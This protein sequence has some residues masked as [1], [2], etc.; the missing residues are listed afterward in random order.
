ME[1]SIVSN[2]LRLKNSFVSYQF[3]LCYEHI[4]RNNKDKSSEVKILNYNHIESM[5]KRKY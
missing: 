4:N 2:K 3:L 5:N 1:I